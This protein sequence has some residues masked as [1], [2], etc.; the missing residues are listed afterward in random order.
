MSTYR[1]ST[2]QLPRQTLEIRALDGARPVEWLRLGF[3]DLRAAPVLSLAYGLVIA[4]LG[5]LFAYLAAGADGFYLVPF[6]FGGFLIVAPVL[7]MGLMAV[8]KL[9][10]TGQ[11]RDTAT[12][13]KIFDLNRPS[14]AMMGI[15]LLLVFVNWIMLSNLV[16]GGV[17]HQITPTYERVQPLPV[18]FSE[19]LPFLVVY[20]GIAIA[21]ATLVFRITALSVPMLLDQKIDAFNAAFASWKAVGENWK[22]MSLWALIIGALCTLGF[23]TYF[24]GLV[25][26]VPW[27]GYA[28][29][30]AY[31]DTMVTLK[32]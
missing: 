4:A 27:L 6:L 26:I 10:E 17:F 9:R 19:S 15:F 21:L 20:A 11:A 7:S 13:R 1:F 29:W 16:Y 2:E 22:P 12:L 31:R 3:A 8:A 28:S 14:S 32:Q 18:M 24:A 5:G 23:L 25:V 30:H